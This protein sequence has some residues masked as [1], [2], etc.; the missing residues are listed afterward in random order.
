MFVLRFLPLAL[1][2]LWSVTC[3]SSSHHKRRCTKPAIRREW[4]TF[5]RHERA[6]WIRAVNCLSHLP[7]DPALAPSVNRSESLATP[8]NSSSSYYDGMTFVF[9][10]LPKDS[11]CFFQTWCTFIWT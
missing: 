6:E 7:H 1:A 8:V 11:N 3:A 10:W 9:G 4:R 2:A 5:S